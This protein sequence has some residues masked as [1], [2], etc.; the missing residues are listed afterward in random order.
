VLAL[1][2]PGFAAHQP[3]PDDLD[4]LTAA[5]AAAL[6]RYVGAAPFLLC[7]HSAGGL[8]AHAVAARLEELG[9]PANGLILLDCYWPGAAL[10]TDLLP[11]LLSSDA[12]TRQVLA[13]AGVSTERLT[14]AGGY[15]RLLAGWQPEAIQAPTLLLRAREP[16]PEVTTDGSRW[17][18][19]HTGL[20]VPGD[21]FTMLTD[22]AAEL[23]D[24]I[25]RW[26]AGAV[27]G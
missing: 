19:A 1:P 10:W 25:G 4:A 2:Q 18:L 12:V 13:A 7:G 9:R 17:R 15:L 16:I 22:H 5:H 24:A 27:A 8:V 14:A 23:A 26:P 21:H 6:D 11:R 20:D 3:L